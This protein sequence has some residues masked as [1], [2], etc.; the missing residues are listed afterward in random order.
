MSRIGAGV[1]A[2]GIKALL[3]D[4][5]GTVRHKLVKKYSTAPSLDELTAILDFIKKEW[6]PAGEE[7]EAVCLGLAAA[8]DH[9][10]GYVYHGPRLGL[11]NVPLGPLLSRK[12]GVPVYLDNDVN[13]TLLAEAVFGDARDFEDVVSL[14]AGAGVGAACLVNGALVRGAHGMGAEA[15]H[16]LFIPGGRPCSC[17]KKGC[18]EAYLGTQAIATRMEE[19]ARSGVKT[20]LSQTGGRDILTLV[21]LSETGDPAARTIWLEA[22]QA[23]HVLTAN[24]VTL[25]DPELIIVSGEQWRSIPGF[26]RDVRQF[27]VT[28]YMHGVL[29]NVQLAW[30]S[31]LEDGTA[32]GA[33]RLPEFSR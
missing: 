8:V 12:L 33:T 28:Q 17:G 21:Q 32:L 25:F 29:F 18:F 9:S 20:A 11:E 4:R 22:L 27:L 15:G 31:Q 23:F 24:L 13:C 14:Q 10:R 26:M 5:D 2:D 16:S 19:A 30:A 1:D 6:S 7:P 3:V